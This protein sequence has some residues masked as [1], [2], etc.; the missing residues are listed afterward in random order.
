MF[1]KEILKQF[2]FVDKFKYFFVDKFKYMNI[3][4]ISLS[5]CDNFII[6]FPEHMLNF[7]VF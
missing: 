6:C 4:L 1:D 2:F 5:K 7:Y 3:N